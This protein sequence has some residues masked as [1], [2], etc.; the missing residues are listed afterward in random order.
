MPTANG[1]PMTFIDIIDAK[2]IDACNEMAN[3]TDTTTSSVQDSPQQLAATSKQPRCTAKKSD[4]P[5]LLRRINKLKPGMKNYMIHACVI[6]KKQTKCQT[7]AVNLLNNSSMICTFINHEQVDKFSPLLEV[8]NVYQISQVQ[9]CKC[10]DQFKLVFT[11]NTTVE[12]YVKQCAKPTNVSQECFDFTLISLLKKYKEK[13]AVDILCIVADIIDAVP[14]VKGTG[15]GMSTRRHLMVVDMS[16]YK[17][18]IMLWGHMVMDFSA[19]IRSVIAFKGAQVNSFDGCTLS[20]MEQRLMAVNPNFPTAHALHKWYDFEGRHMEFQSF[21]NTASTGKS[22]SDPGLQLVMVAA[23][24]SLVNNVDGTIE[25]FHIWAAITY[26]Q[27]KNFTYQSCFGKY[28]AGLVTKVKK[29]CRYRCKIC[30]QSLPKF[31]YSYTLH[32]KVSDG[33][34]KIKL[35]CSDVVGELLFGATANDM[36]KL[37]QLTDKVTFNE[38]FAAA[39]NKSY[40][41]KCKIKSVANKLGTSKI[42]T[43]IS[44]RPIV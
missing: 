40:I 13:Q 42:T 8:D 2:D 23:A 43:A 3:T 22:T 25:F 6:K 28:C 1:S 19:P 30:N 21:S 14:I 4:M 7:V 36:V 29:S 33:T 20:A 37:Q 39:K 17:V 15:N 26:I 5:Y 11:D 16:G 12:Q 44:A 27:F 18:W 41:F 31:K 24:N 10:K 35:Q 34:G 38:M 32:V 9:I